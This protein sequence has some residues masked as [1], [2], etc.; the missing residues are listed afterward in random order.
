MIMAA[1]GLGKGLD[2]LIPNTIG[3]AKE[4]K[5]SKEKV[6]NKN[7]ETMVKLSMVE[8]NGEQPRKNFD[9]DSLLELAESIKQFGLLQPII[10][11]DR[12]NH[13]EIIAGERRWRAAKMAGLKEIPVIIKNLTN[14]E[15]VEISLIENIQREDL[16]PIEEAQAYKRLLEEF[17]LKQDEVAERVSKSRTAVTNSMRL[18]K[19]CDEVQQM[20]VNEMIST[21]HARALLSIEDPEEQYMIAQKVFDEKMSVRE[22]EKL[23]KDLH[24]PEKAP[25]KENKSLEVI[26]Q[27]IENRLKESLGTKVSI[28][29]KNNGA[30]KIEIEFYNHDD[31]DRLM[32]QLM[33]V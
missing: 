32:E 1:R 18:L 17:N 24:K 33:R 21:G 27:N 31:L 13:Y 3:E 6:E 23:V 9:E 29:P 12:K 5:E 2:S 19:L 10:V 15:I 14:Q 28:S 25:K 26:Y 8:P 7:P 16:N 30:G 4:K 22:V 11:Q 20:V